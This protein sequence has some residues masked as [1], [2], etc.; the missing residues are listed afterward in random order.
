MLQ[1]E[2]DN[3]RERGM[4]PR[5]RDQMDEKAEVWVCGLWVFV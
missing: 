1:P 2:I 5:E 3:S 4:E